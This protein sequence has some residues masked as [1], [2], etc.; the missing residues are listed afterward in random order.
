MAEICFPRIASTYPNIYSRR[1]Q[2]GNISS[3][4]PRKKAFQGMVGDVHRLLSNSF[5]DT[6]EAL[7]KSSFC[8]GS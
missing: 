2:A 3:F 6:A 4:K 5:N 1:V 8:V 7:L